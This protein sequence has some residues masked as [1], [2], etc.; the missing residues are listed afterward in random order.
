MAIKEMKWHIVQRETEYPLTW[1]D[2]AIEFDSESE[3]YH[4]AHEASIRLGSEADI[5]HQI[6]YYDGGYIS[7][8]EALTKLLKG[9]HYD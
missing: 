2:R 4:F 8:Q 5:K 6:L 3:A 1:D 7:G 9:K